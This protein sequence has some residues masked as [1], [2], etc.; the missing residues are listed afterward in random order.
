MFD[1]CLVIAYLGFIETRKG[2][3]VMTEHT[4]GPWLCCPSLESDGSY[5][6]FS[7]CGDYLTLNEETHQANA[8]LIAAAPDLLDALEAILNEFNPHAIAKEKIL[9]KA[10]AIIAKAK[11]EPHA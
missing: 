3:T 8:A 7:S 11:G 5:N 10:V 1:L 4:Q 9:Q 6:V 2:E